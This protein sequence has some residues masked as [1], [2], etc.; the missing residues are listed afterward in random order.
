M[1]WANP[2]HKGA[3]LRVVHV[4]IIGRFNHG[5]L[6]MAIP[7]PAVAIPF[8]IDVAVPSTSHTAAIGIPFPSAIKSTDVPNLQPDDKRQIFQSR[9][10]LLGKRRAVLGNS[11]PNATKFVE[12]QN[13]IAVHRRATGAEPCFSHSPKSAGWRGRPGQSRPS[14]SDGAARIEKYCAG[15]VC[16]SPT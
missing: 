12:S 6:Q 16:L 5:P 2:R 11:P 14:R 9:P 13:R 15:A 3:G 7:I 4:R 8:L 1:A 10:I